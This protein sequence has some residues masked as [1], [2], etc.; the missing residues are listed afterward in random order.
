MKPT[1][2]KQKG[3]AKEIHPGFE[4]KSSFQALTLPDVKQA[5]SSGKILLCSLPV[6]RIIAFKR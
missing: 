4:S 2:Q 3:D 6:K 5:P 1:C